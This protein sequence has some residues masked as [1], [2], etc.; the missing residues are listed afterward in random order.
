M[1]AYPVSRGQLL[2]FLLFEN[3]LKIQD[4]ADGTKSCWGWLKGVGAGL[5]QGSVVGDRESR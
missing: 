5:G 2:A 3:G 4:V 1:G